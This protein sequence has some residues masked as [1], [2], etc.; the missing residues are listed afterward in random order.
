MI[1][2]IIQQKLPVNTLLHGDCIQI[3]RQMPANSVDFILTD[4]PYLVNY[5]DHHGRTI[6]NDANADWL[7]PAMEQACRVLK[8]DRVAIMFYGWTR[9]D[10]FFAAWKD[11][12]LQPVGHLVF[13][14]AYSSKTRFLRYQ[15]EQA[16]LLAKGRPPLP[17]EPLADVI[18]MPYSGNKLHPT[19]KPVPM[20]A[21]LIRCFSLPGE[22]VLDA[23]AGS[24]STCASALL[25]GRRYIG[26]E[27]DDEYYAQAS[28]R[29]SRV[30]ERIAAK[31]RSSLVRVPTHV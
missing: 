25:T 16:F 13:R 31:K 6:Q 29:L 20:L 1:T 12:G 4:P 26:I 15:H 14:K 24:G 21:R 27:L 2:N 8:Q 5:R 19:Q 18:D 30:H 23:F 11:A 3:M 7:K 22:T 9:V 17:K 10:A 28:K